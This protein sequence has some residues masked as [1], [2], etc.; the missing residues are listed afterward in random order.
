MDAYKPYLPETGS[1]Y[2]E[3]NGRGRNFELIVNYVLSQLD[4]LDHENEYLKR[5]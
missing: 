2:L 4:L 1:K 5:R 3:A